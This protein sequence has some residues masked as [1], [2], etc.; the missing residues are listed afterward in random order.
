M[1]SKIARSASGLAPFGMVMGDIGER[2]GL[3]EEERQT[4][5]RNI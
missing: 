4:Q 1:S 2:G 5:G 3:G